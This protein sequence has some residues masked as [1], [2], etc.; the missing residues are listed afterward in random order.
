MTSF[1]YSSR[2][3]QT[4]IVLSA[5]DKNTRATLQNSTHRCTFLRPIISNKCYAVP[6]GWRG[7]AALIRLRPSSEPKMRFGLC[8]IPEIDEFFRNSN[9]R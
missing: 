3:R 2:R 7:L 1:E 6:P 5:V 9:Y 8:A 4:G